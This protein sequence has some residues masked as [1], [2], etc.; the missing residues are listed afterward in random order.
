M[1]FLRHRGVNDSNGGGGNSAALLF[2]LGGGFRLPASGRKIPAAVSVH[3]DSRRTVGDRAFPIGP[4]DRLW[5]RL[6]GNR[7][8]SVCAFFRED[9]DRDGLPQDT[10]NQQPRAGLGYS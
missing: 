7:R 8:P 2:T 10:T 3:P 5:S 6:R 4:E 9:A 1:G